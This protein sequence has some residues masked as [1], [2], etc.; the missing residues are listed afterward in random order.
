LRLPM[1]NMI[2]ISHYLWR[3]YHFR[4]EPPHVASND[5]N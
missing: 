5:F 2:S 1:K 4:T 3:K